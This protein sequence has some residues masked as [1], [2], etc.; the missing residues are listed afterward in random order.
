MDKEQ[1]FQQTRARQAHELDQKQQ[2]KYAEYMRAM[3]NV[4][5]MNA[6]T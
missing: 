2:E 4:Q 5:K 6:F 1:K 3:S